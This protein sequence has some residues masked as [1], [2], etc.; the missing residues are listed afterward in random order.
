MVLAETIEVVVAISE[1]EE[2]SEAVETVQGQEVV[3]T[4][5]AIVAEATTA[6]VAPTLAEVTTIAVVMVKTAEAVSE[7]TPVV[8]GAWEEPTVLVPPHQEATAL[9]QL[10]ITEEAPTLDELP[11]SEPEPTLEVEHVRI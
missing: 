2:T 6:V 11:I 4:T 7:D 1:D 9:A 10:R 3:T 5:T 8:L